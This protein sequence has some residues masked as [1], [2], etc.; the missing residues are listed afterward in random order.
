MAEPGDAIVWKLT[1][2]YDGN[3][4]A[5]WQRQPGRR[6][7]QGEL[8]G[9][10]ARVTG[11]R[12]A[13]QGSGRTDT[14]VH[15]MAQVASVALRSPVPPDNLRRAL[16]HRLPPSIRILAAEHAPPGFHARHSAL[17]KTY[18]YRL[19][20]AALCPPWLAPYVCAYTFPLATERMQAAARAVL[21]THD[22]GSFQAPEPDVSGRAAAR[23]TARGV[24]EF[25][26]R[27]AVRTLFQSRWE[28]PEPDLLVYRVSG[29][30]FLHHMVRNL[31]GTFL[32]VGRGQIAA[33]ALP[34]ILAARS[35]SAAGPTAPASG[36]WLHSV[37]YAGRE[38]GQDSDRG[39]G[40]TL[41]HPELPA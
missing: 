30:G 32:A 8:E 31:V 4:F 6:T 21:G 2:C 38:C 28:M 40:A 23:A 19:F 17:R 41:K 26:K 22:F 29:S 9:A 39:A 3:P 5:G 7:V 11:E 36:L 20:R 15:A 1:L 24:T 18:D 33:D 27:T 13:A 16:N 14:G 35:R 12:A 25:R 34:A 10:I 37:E